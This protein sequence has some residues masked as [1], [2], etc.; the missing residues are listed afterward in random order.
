MTLDVIKKIMEKYGEYKIFTKEYKRFRADKENARN[1]KSNS[2]IEYLH[3]LIK[4]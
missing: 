1:H 4:G 2:T 3:C